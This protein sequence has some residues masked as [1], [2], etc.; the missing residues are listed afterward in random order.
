MFV[1]SSTLS[2]IA[3]GGVGRPVAVG[4]ATT[5]VRAMTSAARARVRRIST[6]SPPGP[7]FLS[8]QGALV[9]SPTVDRGVEGLRRGVEVD[10]AGEQLLVGRVRVRVGRVRFFD[11]HE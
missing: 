9:L 5:V 1:S 3:S 8:R 4:A 10:E 6:P 2:D 11:A 7:G